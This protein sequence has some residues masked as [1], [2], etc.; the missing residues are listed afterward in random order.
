VRFGNFSGLSSVSN[1]L[2]IIAMI[3]LASIRKAG[4]RR[5][6]HNEFHPLGQKELPFCPPA[7]AAKLNPQYC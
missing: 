6:K 1:K 7:K 4:L 5:T 2:H 3:K